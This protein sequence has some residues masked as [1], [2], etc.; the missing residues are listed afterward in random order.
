[1]FYRALSK[2]IFGNVKES[3]TIEISMAKADFGGKNL[4]ASGA[5]LLAAFLPMCT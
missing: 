4:G 1:M 2:V 5:I 3:V